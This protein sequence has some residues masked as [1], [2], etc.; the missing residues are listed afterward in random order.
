MNQLPKCVKAKSKMPP[1]NDSFKQ[2]YA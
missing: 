1:S 2:L